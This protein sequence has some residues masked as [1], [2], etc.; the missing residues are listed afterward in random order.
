MLNRLTLDLIRIGDPIPVGDRHRLLYSAARNL[1][2]FGCSTELARAL[3][4]DPGLDS[5]LPPFE[6]VEQGELAKLK[7]RVAANLADAHLVEGQV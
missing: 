2:E 1:A 5:S 6:F 7:P 3:L 4:T